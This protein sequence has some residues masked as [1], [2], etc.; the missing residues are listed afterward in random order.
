MGNKYITKY[1]DNPPPGIYN[2]EE[3]EK[4]TRSKSF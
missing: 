2:P 1:D 3:G 4:M